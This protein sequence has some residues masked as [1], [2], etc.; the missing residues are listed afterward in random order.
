MKK[1]LF[2]VAAI[3]DTVIAFAQAN[4]AAASSGLTPIND[5]GTGSFV[6]A[7]AATWTGGLYPNGSNYRPAT[8]M[9][10]GISLAQQVVPLDATGNIDNVNGKIVWLSIGMSNATMETQQFIPL[11]NAYANKNP[12]LTFVDGAQGSMTA[13]VISTPSNPNYATYWNTIN[14]RLATAGV[15]SSQVEVIW[16][17][18]ANP[19]SG[20]Q[21]QPYYDS[22]IVQYK[23]IMNNIKVRFPNVK[24]C[25]MAS[26]I[27]AR[28]ASSTLNPEPYAY[29]TG[30]AVK[31]VIED[32][33]NGDPQLQYSG[34]GANSPFLSYGIYMW[35]DG[36]TPELTNPNVFWT[37]PTDFTTDG[38]HPSVPTGAAK[39][40]NL[41]LTFFQNDTL[42][43]P[44]FFNTAPAW[45]GVVGIQHETISGAALN[46][47]PN[48]FSTTT[49]IQIT[50]S[51]LKNKNLD[52]K[53]YNL[54]GQE[55]MQ[56]RNIKNET[57]I[58][59]SN[60]LSGIYILK[61][62]STD[63]NKFISVNK[64]TIE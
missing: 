23:R 48:P 19:A 45:C 1:V 35:S 14:T 33:I 27:S 55:I 38:T 10:A 40:A 6:N 16:F 28:Y 15:T 9:A 30:W 5:L 36:S 44:W 57:I 32:Q 61:L 31:K 8:H 20:S 54:F 18:E 49:T 51:E 7:W 25:Y 17:K 2:L 34:P 50:S 21:I 37:C 64:I 63:D 46:I 52:L 42:S 39:V 3:A 4:C 24:L 22:L 13:S 59:R 26:R 11:A 41:L 47:F 60:F 12:K 43:C 58:D 29:Y 53:L 56:T 62:F